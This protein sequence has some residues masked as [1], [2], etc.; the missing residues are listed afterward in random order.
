VKS[1]LTPLLFV[2]FLSTAAAHA[3]AAQGDSPTSGDSTTPTAPTDIS[4]E[5]G[6]LS[7]KLDRNQGVI[8]PER[9]VDPGMAKKPPETGSTP[10][11]QPPDPSKS[12]VEPK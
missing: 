12:G 3:L 8:H 6:V 1:T 7:D 5:H 4:R 9:G 11:V 10:I 2:G